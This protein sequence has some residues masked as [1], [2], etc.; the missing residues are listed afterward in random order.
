MN[1][2]IPIRTLE[3][4]HTCRQDGGRDHI[5]ASGPFLSENSPRQWLTQGYYFWVADIE[6][7][8]HWGENSIDGDY[9]IMKVRV[10]FSEEQVLDLV[11]SPSQIKAFRAMLAKF[12]QVMVRQHG[13]RYEPTVSE[14]IKYFRRVG[15]FPFK[16]VMAAEEQKA[17]VRRSRFIASA[18]NAIAL[19]PRH[20]FCLF[21]GAEELV[22]DKCIVEPAHWAA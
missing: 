11:G 5:L 7:A 17:S 18:D 19:N 10:S 22:T 16:G 6:H 3:L 15:R 2:E 9:A 8:R 21:E 12:M 14:C 4:F 13:G 20:Q 1:M